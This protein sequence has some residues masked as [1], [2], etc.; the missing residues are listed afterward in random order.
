MPFDNCVSRMAHIRSTLLPRKQAIS[1][2]VISLTTF[3]ER[4]PTLWLTLSS[5][6]AQT[7]LP[8]KIYVHVARDE[9]LPD[10]DQ[11]YIDEYNNTD[12]VEI[13][14]VE[15]NFKSYNKLVHIWRN[16]SGKRVITVD[17]DLYYDRSLLEK[18]VAASDALPDK[19]ICGRGLCMLQ[20]SEA[21]FIPFLFWPKAVEIA[22]TGVF[23][24]GAAG[25]LYPPGCLHT[26]VTN[27]VLF[28][29]LAPGNDDIWFHTAAVLHGTAVYSVGVDWHNHRHIAIRDNRTLKS[30]NWTGQQDY[31]HRRV[32]EHYGLTPKD[33]VQRSYFLTEGGAPLLMDAGPRSAW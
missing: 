9:V 26:D 6:L 18:L 22:G 12:R 19:I 30:K 3:P 5:L 32:M 27:S 1:D 24:Q 11:K 25:V 29:E 8:E 14:I 33:I 28:E 21:E 10:R 4:L 13:I 20:K 23:L 31:C 17:D 2:V 15:L 7:V 16:L